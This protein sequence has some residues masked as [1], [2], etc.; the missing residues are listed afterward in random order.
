MK[1]APRLYCNKKACK[2]RDPGV[3]HV[4]Q[5]PMGWDSPIASCGPLANLKRNPVPFQ[6]CSSSWKEEDREMANDHLQA[7]NLSSYQ[8]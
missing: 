6:S 5:W 8:D 7:A 2:H 3:D 1:K 4:W